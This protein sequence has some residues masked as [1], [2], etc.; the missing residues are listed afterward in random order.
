MLALSAWNLTLTFF[1][2]EIADG[3]LSGS[4]VL[5][6]DAAHLFTEPAALLRDEL[7]MEHAAVQVY[8]WGTTV[9][10]EIMRGHE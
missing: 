7:G 1:A 5:L 6:A 8:F 2:V 3:L 9:T 10:C 4:L